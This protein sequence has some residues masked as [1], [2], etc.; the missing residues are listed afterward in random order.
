MRKLAQ[1]M[2]QILPSSSSDGSL[3]AFAKSELTS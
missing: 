3:Y 1:K 2:E